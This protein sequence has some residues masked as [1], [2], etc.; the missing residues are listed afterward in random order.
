LLVIGNLLSVVIP[1]HVHNRPLTWS[2][3]RL[4]YCSK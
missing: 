1:Y 4:T 2:L 3:M